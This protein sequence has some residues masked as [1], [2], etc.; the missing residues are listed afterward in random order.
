MTRIGRLEDREVQLV[1]LCVVEHEGQVIERDDLVQVTGEDVKQL[2]DGPVRG[3][4]PRY[5]QQR[6]VPRGID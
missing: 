1:V 5:V 3:K 6:V 4:A 2:R